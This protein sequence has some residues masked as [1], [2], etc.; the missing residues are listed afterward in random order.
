VLQAFD[1]REA[2]Q[3][4]HRLGLRRLFMLALKEQ[5]KFLEKI[6]SPAKILARP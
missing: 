6:Y 4:A 1:T 5:V 3:M 2:A